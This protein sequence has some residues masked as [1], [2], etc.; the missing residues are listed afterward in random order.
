MPM[1]DRAKK[2]EK[3]KEFQPPP[4]SQTTHIEVLFNPLV[5]YILIAVSVYYTGYYIGV[6]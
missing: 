1:S 5:L 6:E 2:R 3:K 4:G